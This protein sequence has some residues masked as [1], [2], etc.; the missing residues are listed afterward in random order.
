M[1]RHGPAAKVV[2]IPGVGHAPALVTENLIGVVRD[3]LSATA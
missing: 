1:Q 2:D 3:W